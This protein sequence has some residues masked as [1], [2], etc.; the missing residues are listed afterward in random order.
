MSEQSSSRV[1][2]STSRLVGVFGG[3]FAPI[4]NGHLRL[5]IEARERL[6]L[7]HVRLI[8]T[9]HPPHREDSAI[10]A[11]RRLEWVRRAIADEPGL[12]A[13]DRELRRAG[14]SYTFDT[15][16]ELKGEFPDASLCLLVG[17]DALH[18]LHSWKDWPRLL[19]LAHLVS[20]PRP[21]SDALPAPA[22]AQFLRAARAESMDELYAK[23]NGCW[24]ELK[25]PP[26][27]ISSTRI[28]ALAAENRSLR[29]LVPDTVLVHMTPLELEKLACNER[30]A[31]A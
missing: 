30:S 26:L 14:H 1:P 6:G 18:G 15:L 5:A 27:A 10:P 31:A 22:V 24:L 8:P 7:D 2:L 20:V 9:G 16:A 29:G 11:E 13:D 12:V 4:H 21:E 28:R 17:N 25:L 3:A 19:E 23:P